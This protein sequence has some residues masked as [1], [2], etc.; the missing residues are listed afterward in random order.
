VAN[1]I[2][3][4]DGKTNG[5]LSTALDEYARVE[6]EMYAYLILTHAQGV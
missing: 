5:E 3:L 6:K 4:R 1:S 2:A